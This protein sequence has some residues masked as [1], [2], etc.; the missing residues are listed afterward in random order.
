MFN[1]FNV[2][3]SPIKFFKRSSVTDFALT[4]PQKKRTFWSQIAIYFGQVPIY[5]VNLAKK[6]RCKKSSLKCVLSVALEPLELSVLHAVVS[7]TLLSLYDLL[8][9]LRDSRASYITYLVL[10]VD[11]CFRVLAPL[12]L[13]YFAY[14]VP[15]ALRTLTFNILCT[16]ELP[17]LNSAC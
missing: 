5:K 17:L 13:A 4:T 2:P 15:R 12:V 16:M 1:S 14:P 7:R 3:F 11:S 9:F 8:P 6:A 10:Q